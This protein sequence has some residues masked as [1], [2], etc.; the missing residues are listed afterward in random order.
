MAAERLL[1][2]IDLERCPFEIFPLA[3][4]F[5]KPFGGEVVLLHVLKPG[6]AAGGPAGDLAR[7]HLEQISRDFIR[8][9]IEARPRVRAGIPH[10]EIFAE[11]AAASADLILLPVHLPSIWRRLVGSGCGSTARNVVAGA[12]CGVFVVTVRTRF[13]CLRRWGARTLSSRCAA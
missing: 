8:P 12:P 7:R 13:N 10:E 3:N 1:L 5:A 11:A 4:G 9:S 2:P 6:S